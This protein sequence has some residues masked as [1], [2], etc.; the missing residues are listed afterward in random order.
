MRLTF[1]IALQ[2]DYHI[3]AGHGDGAQVDS[4]LHRDADQV[5]VWRSAPKGLLRDGLWHLLQTPPLADRRRC[6]ASG[7]TDDSAPPHCSDA[8]CP[9]CAIVGVPSQ[10]HLTRWQFSSA[11]PVGLET[12]LPS[13]HSWVR[14]Q[15]GSQVT[16]RVRVNP[17]MRRAASQQLF[18]Q[19]EGDKRLTFRFTADCAANNATAHHEA[20]LMV[21]AAR[22]VRRMGAARRRGRGACL[23]GV[24]D[25]D[26]WQLERAADA[27]WQDHLLTHFKAV[28]LNDAPPDVLEPPRVWTTPSA[29]SDTSPRSFRLVVRLDEPCVLAR[30]AEAGNIFDCSHVIS[31][32]TILGALAAEAAKR[33]DLS[34]PE[35]YAAFLRTFREG[36]VHFYPLYPMHHK[37]EKLYPAIPAPRDLLVCK[38]RQLDPEHQEL[39]SYA[40]QDELPKACPQ[41]ERDIPMVSP[42]G[43]VALS[44]QA[45]LLAPNVREEIHPRIDPLTQRVA[46][47]NLFG[48]IALESGQYFV[49]HL[50]CRDAHAW[51]TLCKLTEI[52]VANQVFPL[53]L[54]KATGRGYG[55]ASAWLQ[56]VEAAD[57]D[58]WR[59]APLEQRVIHLDQ[60]ITMTLLTDA[61]LPD[62]WGRFHQTLDD[63]V[64]Q[65]WLGNW[66]ET[67]IRTFCRS[68]PVD[69]FNN[70]LGLPRSRDIA[71]QAG[72]AVGF[73]VR[74]TS[75]GAD[76]LARLRQLEAD[77]I[78]LR[79]HEGFGQVV[80]NHPVYANGEGI[81]APSLD[82]RGYPE[83]QLTLPDAGTASAKMVDEFDF[84]KRITQDVMFEARHFQDERWHAVSRWLHGHAHLPT[85]EL[86]EQLQRFGD[87]EV[88]GTETRTGKIGF[89][90]EAA[91]G[92]AYLSAQL[93]D[94]ATQNPTLN[95]IAI[96]LLAN[97]IAASAQPGDVN[98]A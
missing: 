80:F 76:V 63:P 74:P 34:S 41:C 33:W 59:M 85:A 78:G 66:V 37:D 7:L 17:R 67:S 70:H 45:T 71:I 69:H 10:P 88:W 5:P 72:S 84:I 20:A 9:F 90:Q 30:R 19:E 22:M 42:N 14:G 44:H 28:W 79:A 2:S 73:R 31:G 27:S 13:N 64:L 83:L 95:R 68:G 38:V 86:I 48:Y 52:V 58:L 35:T 60:P 32:P 89:A 93:A 94:V 47:G 96:E 91:S 4:L 36:Q 81:D 50:T 75:N 82:L 98:H 24:E 92:I 57:A 6:R 11:R 1:T 56:P 15:T 25:V 62:A 39:K 3:G 54:G 26:G 49:G 40:M 61:I 87:A 29:S 16:A 51:Q 97:R 23:V 8:P 53:R 18:S 43:F 21:A 46:T 77:G 12:L 65:E 55:R